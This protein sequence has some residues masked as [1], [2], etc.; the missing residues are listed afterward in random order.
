MI[1][2][3]NSAS[4]PLVSVIVPTRNRAFLL[5]RALRSV[6]CQTYPNLE[7]VVV[8]DASTDET[9][10]VVAGFNNQAIHY[11]RH[12]SSKGGSAARNT[13]IRAATGKYVAFLDDDDEWEPVKTEEQVKMLQKYDVV[14]CTSNEDIVNLGKL[15]RK[16]EVTLDDLRKGYFTA[17]GTGVLMASTSAMRE[18]MFDEDLPRGQDWDVFIRLA[19]KYRV[20]YLNQP[21]VRYNEGDHAR[22]SNEITNMP[23]TELVKRLRI[24]EKHKA[25]FG[26]RWFK[27]H[28]SRFLLYQVR[29]RTNKGQ[30]LLFTVRTCGIAAVTWALSRRIYLRLTGSI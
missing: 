26:P 3:N 17:G 11:I 1:A 9:R 14:F 23:A 27:R 30:H 25:F 5:K 4:M 18:V 21:L 8:D 7:I 28:M 16:T 6:L 10:D 19:Q 12:D 24:L 13:G 20:G 15:D 2:D 22:I 29:R